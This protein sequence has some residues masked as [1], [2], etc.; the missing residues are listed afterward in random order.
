MNKV[1]ISVPQEFNNEPKSS[2]SRA[3]RYERDGYAR[4]DEIPF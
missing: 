1:E 4:S 3:L 2:Q